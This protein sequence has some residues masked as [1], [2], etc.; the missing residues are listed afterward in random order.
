M[1]VEK[2]PAFGGEGQGKTIEPV[3]INGFDGFS[4]THDNLLWSHSSGMITYTL[5][6]KIIIESTRTRQQTVLTESEVR[7]STLARSP[8]ERILAA[9]EGEASRFGNA[10]IYL[11][12]LQQNKLMNKITF[13]RHGVQSMAFS[14]CGKFLIAASV[15]EE[16]VLVVLDV[17]SGLV[18]ENGTVILEEHQNINKI[19]VNPYPDLDVDF[20]TIGQK[21]C[22]LLWKYDYEM[23][24]ILNIA[25]E[26][27]QDLQN[28]DFT[29]A[30]YTQKLPAP[31]HSELVILGMA[32]GAVA[33]VNPNPKDSS[34]VRKLDWLEHGKK[35]FVLGEAISSIIYRYSQV[36]I[37]GDQG[38]VIRYADKHGQVMP[39]DDRDM[40]TRLKTEDP[41]TAI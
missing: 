12:D 16:N 11:F 7:L 20:I 10:I 32:D 18:C 31:Y 3:C 5:H 14:N 24:Q 39:P 8:N 37:A 36:V 28:S 26:M 6:N 41:I 21:G 40:I 38:S 22:F 1:Q 13:F 17:N 27:S 35:E 4:G 19:V 23:Q 2:G 34:N 9:A 33:A 30:V 29:C 15:P 25:P